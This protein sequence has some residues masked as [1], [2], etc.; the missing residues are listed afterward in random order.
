LPLIFNGFMVNACAL[1]HDYHFNCNICRVPIDPWATQLKNGFTPHLA[2]M[3]T[4]PQWCPA[5]AVL[6]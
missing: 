6:R 2:P 3:F 1:P 4:S 5:S